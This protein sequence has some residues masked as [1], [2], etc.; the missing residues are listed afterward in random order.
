[1]QVEVTWNDLK[2]TSSSLQQRSEGGLNRLRQ[3]VYVASCMPYLLAHI[4]EAAPS[5]APP[6]DSLLTSIEESMCQLGWREGVTAAG[7]EL[8][9]L[10]LSNEKRLQDVDS[11]LCEGVVGETPACIA[12]WN[13]C[14]QLARLH[15]HLAACFSSME[16]DEALE[17]AANDQLVKLGETLELLCSRTMSSLEEEATRSSN[18]TQLGMVVGLVVEGLAFWGMRPFLWA[19]LSLSW[20]VAKL[21][22]TGGKKSER[23]GATHA[24]MK[25]MMKA[26][27]AS[28][29]SSPSLSA[30]SDIISPLVDFWKEKSMKEDT[31]E[32]QRQTIMHLA[33]DGREAR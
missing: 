10:S 26:L 17:E 16:K 21:N 32:K 28:V 9:K 30:H 25:K 5:V 19:E 20:W 33:K 24:A 13:F 8:E 15:L 27:E 6:L 31:V 1:M 2:K 3:Q 12:G 11:F 22:A 14:T 23:V 18:S 29:D 7:V 4:L